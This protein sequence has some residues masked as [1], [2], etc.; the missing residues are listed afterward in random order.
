MARPNLKT[1]E[2]LLS[3]FAESVS[4]V[5]NEIDI[6]QRALAESGRTS[7]QAKYF[8]TKKILKKWFYENGNR[9]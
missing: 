6:N 1:H 5:L 9:Y 4:K 3:Y 7:D 2:T 8:R